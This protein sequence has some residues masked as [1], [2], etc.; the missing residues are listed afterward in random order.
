MTYPALDESVRGRPDIEGDTRRLLD[1]LT[2][3]GVAINLSGTG[4][5]HR[6]E[7][8]E[9]EIIAAAD[10]ILDYGLSRYHY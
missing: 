6:V 5:K 1:V 10:L 9:P 7:D 4:A 8:M 2:N 3:G